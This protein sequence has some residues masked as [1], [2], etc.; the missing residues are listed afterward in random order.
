MRRFSAFS[1]MRDAWAARSGQP[2]PVEPLWRNPSPKPRYRFLIIGG[3]GHG[4]AAAYHLA[5]DHGITDVAVLEKG[6]IGGGNAG[7]NATIIRSNYLHPA[8]AALYDSALQQWEGLSKALN[9]N[10]LFSARGLLTLH[11][12]P[13]D[14]YLGMRLIHAGRPVGVDGDYLSPAEAKAICPPLDISNKARLPVTGATL[15]RRAG[16]ARHDAVVWG[17]ARAADAR[18]VDILENCPVTALRRGADGAI[19]GVETAKGPI[20]AQTVLLTSASASP[21]LAETAG[22]SLPLLA[23]PLQAWVSESLRPVLPCVVMSNRLQ[24]HISQADK[25][26]LVISTGTDQAPIHQNAGA[27]QVVETA[28]A[29]LLALF[30]RFSR[31]RMLRIWGGVVDTS[32]DASPILGESGI[33]GLLLNC[34]W[35]TGGFKATPAAGRLA[36]HHLATGSPHD[37]AQPFALERFNSGHEID[38]R[39]CAGVTQ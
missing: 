16:V 36:A 25:G 22:L 14:D 2:P 5:R 20:E 10:V 19:T 17:Y 11:H 15:Q 13:T 34:G 31:V 30:P 27:P 35:G 39:F 26:E 38:E 3:G 1:L 4:L 12:S 18:G 21:A 9:F 6:R 33:K 24:A 28:L 32:P 29:S 7:R 23:K 8:S 37:L